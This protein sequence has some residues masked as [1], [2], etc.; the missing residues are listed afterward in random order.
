MILT[1]CSHYSLILNHSNQV[2]NSHNIKKNKYKKKYKFSTN[3]AVPKETCFSKSLFLLEKLST[4]IIYKNLKSGHII[5]LNFS[6]SFDCCLP[7]TKIEIFIK[8]TK[9]KNTK[10]DIISEN[11]ILAKEFSIIFSKIFSK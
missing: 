5:A 7:S 8:D 11:M 2:I 10:I 6:E 4:N 3:F 9:S 1:S